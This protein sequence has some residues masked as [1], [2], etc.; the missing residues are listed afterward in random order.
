MKLYANTPFLLKDS[1][2]TN[3]HLDYSSVFQ[4]LK[5][6]TG[7]YIKS[8]K[9]LIVQINELPVLDLITSFIRDIENSYI[10]VLSKV[11][12]DYK[13]EKIFIKDSTFIAVSG[14]VLKIRAQMISDYQY[15]KFVR[16]SSKD[17]EELE[18]YSFY[19]SY[20]QNVKLKDR[21]PNGCVILYSELN[22]SL[23][24]VWNKEEHEN[25]T[26]YISDK[27]E[28]VWYEHDTF[29]RI[30]CAYLTEASRSNLLYSEIEKVKL[31]SRWRFSKTPRLAANV[32]EKSG[33]IELLISKCDIDYKDLRNNLGTYNNDFDVNPNEFELIDLSDIDVL[34]TFYNFDYTTEIYDPEAELYCQ[35]V[36]SKL[37]L[38]FTKLRKHILTKSSTNQGRV[39]R[40]NGIHQE[41]T[42][43][44]DLRI[45]T[46]HD[47]FTDDDLKVLEDE[48]KYIYEFNIGEWRGKAY[49]TEYVKNPIRSVCRYSP[50]L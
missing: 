18:Q 21:V 10:V 5:E 13:R 2:T 31:G 27:G 41:D 17:S 28:S 45:I 4:H 40:V 1:Y 32:E 49:M 24:D 8:S 37:N 29:L 3:I 44:E 35:P 39:I 46:T 11:G 22:F 30:L 19:S 20:E 23:D 16:L 42:S 9:L 7:L 47:D 6:N 38:V 26:F 12:D 43:R 15:N 50:K 33:F 14:D 36:N 25:K 48:F 34:K